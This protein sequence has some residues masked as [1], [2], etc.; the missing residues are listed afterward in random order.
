[1]TYP[2][3]SAIAPGNR[4]ALAVRVTPAPGIHVYAPGAQGYRPVK[5]QVA[6]QPYVRILPLSYPPSEIYFFKPLNERVPV[7]RESFTLLQDV[8]LEV[9]LEAAKA[10][11]GRKELRLNGS[12]EYQACDQT[13]CF[14]PAS[15]PL[16]W[17][18]RLTPHNI[19]RITPP[20]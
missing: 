15:V 9:S 18:L 3:D 17:T 11:E 4:F 13:K 8:V 7:Y 5:L 6:G 2:S 16:S 12:L 19:P 20:R 1:V 14:N 10:L